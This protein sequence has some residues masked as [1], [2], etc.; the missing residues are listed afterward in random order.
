LPGN[1]Y[2]VIDWDLN[3]GSNW[4]LQNLGFPE[5]GFL[6]ALV[7]ISTLT[8]IQTTIYTASFDPSKS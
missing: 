6:L 3:S 1:L 2:F 8:L 5:S 4:I 7:L